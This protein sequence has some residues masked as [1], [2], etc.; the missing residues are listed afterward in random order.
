AVTGRDVSFLLRALEADGR[1]EVLSRPQILTADNQKATIN[2]GQRVPLVTDSRV[3]GQSDNPVVINSYKY[4]DV[5]V[6]LTVTPKISPDGFVKMEIE[7]TV[8][9]ISSS[10]VE[11]SPG[12][13]V[14]IIAQRK[15]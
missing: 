15:A 6:I 1:L 9:Q 12:V 3:S 8:S 14:P 5:G 7:P 4:E 2:V 10:Q 11:V 13:N